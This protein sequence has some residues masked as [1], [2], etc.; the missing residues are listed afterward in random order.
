MVTMV[1]AMKEIAIDK[2]LVTEIKK[3]KKKK[4]KKKA[5]ESMT[6]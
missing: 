3:K 4:K 1:K 6:W 2:A 5:R